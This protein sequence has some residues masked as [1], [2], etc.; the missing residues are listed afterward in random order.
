MP[1]EVGFA[2]DHFSNHQ[3]HSIETMITSIQWEKN[4]QKV[5]SKVVMKITIW[6][7]S[8]TNRL[9]MHLLKSYKDMN[10]RIIKRK[11]KLNRL[12]LSSGVDRM[13]RRMVA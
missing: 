10:I 4:I 2:I 1:P 7:N 3:E 5:I 11:I 9:K 13:L 6:H 8:G 12:F